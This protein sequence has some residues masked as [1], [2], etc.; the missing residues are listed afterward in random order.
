[1]FCHF[2]CM[3]YICS[4]YILCLFALF[5]ICFPFAFLNNSMFVLYIL[6]LFL[7]KNKCSF[8]LFSIC[9]SHISYSFYILCLFISVLLSCL[10]FTGQSSLGKYIASWSLT[11]RRVSEVMNE[12]R[13]CKFSFSPTVYPVCVFVLFV[14]FLVYVA[15]VL[16]IFCLFFFLSV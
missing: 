15:P 11:C 7:C 6:P 12:E 2:L 8:C 14:V 9:S 3:C 16:Y 10:C 5:I 13:S 1:M 4:V